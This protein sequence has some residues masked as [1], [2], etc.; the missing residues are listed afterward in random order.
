MQIINTWLTSACLGLLSLASTPSIV[1]PT[2]ALE[3]KTKILVIVNKSNPIDA[4]SI[5]QVRHLFLRKDLTWE[6]VLTKARGKKKKGSFS[7]A[8][9]VRP[10][11]F[12]RTVENRLFLKHVLEKDKDALERHWI[13]LQYQSAIRRPKRV[14]TPERVLKYTSALKGCIGF[15]NADAL[16]EVDKKRVKVVLVLEL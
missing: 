9:K 5:A 1:E 8:E 16:R 10:I 15:I 7:Y 4:L 2:S 12:T 6:R 3:K 14:G 11:E 13:K